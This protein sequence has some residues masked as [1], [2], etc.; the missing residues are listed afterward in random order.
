[1][2]PL[3]KRWAGRNAY[4]LAAICIALMAVMLFPLVMSLLTSGR[5]S[6][7]KLTRAIV[8]IPVVSGIG[9]SSL[10]WVWLFQPQIGLFNKLLVDLHI[11]PK[12]L[13]WFGADATLG[14]W[15]VI[16]SITW[17][18]VGFGMILF[19]A[20]IQSIP[21][22]IIEVAKIDGA[23]YWQ[24]VAKIIVP[25]NYRIILL[26]T[27]ISAIG[28]MLAFEQF[29]IMTTGAPENQTITSVYWIYTNSFT[30]FQLGYGSPLSIMLMIIIVAGTSIEIALT[31]RRSL[32]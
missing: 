14:L 15:G 22:E 27:L 28:S 13:V 7:I 6:M 26:V 1:M 5:S 19:V 25:L 16:I 23:S 8:F 29:Y 30:Y 20:G 4:L 3:T 32:E 24:R 21:T 18:V 31:R 9:S 2:S 12:P 17:K 11:I 10:L